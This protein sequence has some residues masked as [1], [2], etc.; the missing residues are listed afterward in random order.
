MAIDCI[1]CVEHA[2]RVDDG[3][4]HG[5]CECDSRWTGVDCSEYDQAFCHPTCNGCF[6][7]LDRDCNRCNDHAFRDKTGA[8]VCKPGWESHDCSTWVGLCDDRCL[9]CNGPT[10][11]D[12]LAC[13]EN[14]QNLA[15]E[16]TCLTDWTGSDCSYYKGRCDTR[17]RG[18]HGP[19]NADCE[20]CVEHAYKNDDGECVCDPMW[21]DEL[22][23]NK[24]YAP[25]Q[26]LC[27]D[28]ELGNTETCTACFEGYYLNGNGNCVLCDDSCKTCEGMST[29]CTGCHDGWWLNIGVCEI[30]RAECKTCSDG[31][32]CDDCWS[33]S[34]L[35]GNGQCICDVGGRDK[36]S[37]MCFNACSTGTTLDAMSGVCEP[38]AMANVGVMLDGPS[39]VLT[40]CH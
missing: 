6:G 24:P 16:C 9:D 30:C 20:Y 2:H 40:S 8:C 3:S 4:S 15:G 32:T 1:A 37:R 34:Q 23:C 18:C 22:H 33:D 14:T 31:A 39:T 38:D 26:I 12:C 27:K 5:V 36:A 11:R 19:T 29:T 25:C 35:S 10:N 28:C 13:V 17:C 7:P 21:F